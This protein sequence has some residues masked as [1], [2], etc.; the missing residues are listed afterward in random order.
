MPIMPQPIAARHDRRSQVTKLYFDTTTGKRMQEFYVMGAVSWPEGGREGFAILG[1][2]NVEDKRVL[3]FREFRFLTIDHWIGLDNT[4]KQHGFIKFLAEAWADFRC[5]YFF[6]SQ[7]E[8]LHRR[9]S[10]ECYKNDMVE[11]K[12]DFIRVL[13][14][15][16]DIGD[17]VIE[18]FLTLRRLSLNTTMNIEGLPNSM[19]YSQLR[20][21]QSMKDSPG[22][23]VNEGT[24]ALRCML[25]G[26]IYNPLPPTP[27]EIN[28]TELPWTGRNK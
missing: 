17:N 18:E 6:F 11:P 20:E 3:P 7:N 24:H 26:F 10:L 16:Q 5:R 1:G 14:A 19:L 25:G 28:L 12:P 2:Q 21:Y 15:D 22:K 13:Y 23:F 9:F 4:L 8:E 27:R